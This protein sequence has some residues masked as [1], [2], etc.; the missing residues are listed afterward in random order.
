MSELNTSTAAPKTLAERLTEGR[1]PVTEGLRYAMIVAEALRKTHDEGR[2]HGAVAPCN[3]GMTATGVELLPP[4]LS[5]A[6]MP[7]VAPEVLAG[8]PADAR[9]DVFSFAAMLYEILTGRAPFQDKDRTAPLPTGSAAVDRLVAS[10]LGADP[11]ARV[12]R[13][14]KVMLELK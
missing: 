13:M 10:C 14:Q 12:Q 6:A 1:I 2:A 4:Q 9:S 7:Y 5:P 3:I 11:A 8:N